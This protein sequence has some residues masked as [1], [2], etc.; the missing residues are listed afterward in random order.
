M[1]NCASLAKHWYDFQPCHRGAWCVY[2]KWAARAAFSTDDINV[3]RYLG[4]TS[5]SILTSHACMDIGSLDHAHVVPT[6]SNAADV[7]LNV[8]PD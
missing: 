4:L 6:I 7:L 3:Y 8:A 5:P 2:G 1:T